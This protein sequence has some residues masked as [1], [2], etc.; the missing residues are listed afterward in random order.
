M[1]WTV[2]P[3]GVFNALPDAALVPKPIAGLVARHSAFVAEHREL[4]RKANELRAQRDQVAAA[5]EQKIA[6]SMIARRDPPANPLPDYDA[7]IEDYT[8]RAQ[9]ALRAA[10]QVYGE[11]GDKL[12]AA[13]PDLVS[14]A[15]NSVEVAV[16]EALEAIDVIRPLLDRVGDEIALLHWYQSI[17]RQAVGY[18]TA[19][20]ERT[21]IDESLGR[22]LSVLR[23]TANDIAESREPEIVEVDA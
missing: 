3:R 10:A 12:N 18:V 7:G 4:T 2:S 20:A 15:T 23:H 8:H 11:I 6:E 1:A 5:Y 21:I 17:E 9:G 13:K 16:S 14:Q 22:I 19:S